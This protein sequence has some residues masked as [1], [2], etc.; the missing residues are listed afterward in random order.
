MPAVRSR[1]GFTLIELM[2]S[3]AILSLVL[4]GTFSAMGSYLRLGAAQAQENLLQQ[5]FRFAMDTIS[6]DARQA[7]AVGVANPNDY[8]SMFVTD[9]LVFQLPEPDGWVRYRVLP[10]VSAGVVVASELVR[11]RGTYLAST[12]TFTPLTPA[13]VQPVTEN[14]PQL[15]QAY[16]VTSGSRVFVILVGRMTYS[17]TSRDVSLVSLVYTRNVGGSGT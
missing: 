1:R 8:Y 7:L 15:L 14:I 4:M 13:V 6:T 9:N 2:V 3:M 11:E 5:N 12:A 17:G 16:F 10:T